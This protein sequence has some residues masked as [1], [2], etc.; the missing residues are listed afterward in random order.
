MYLYK[1]ALR[2]KQLRWIC[3]RCRRAKVRAQE[4]CTIWIANLATQSFDPFMAIASG[5]GAIMAPSTPLHCGHHQWHRCHHGPLHSI[6]LWPTL[7]DF[8][9]FLMYYVVCVFLKYQLMVK[10]SQKCFMCGINLLMF[11][12]T[13]AIF[14]L[15]RKPTFQQQQL[16]L[17]KTRAKCVSIATFQ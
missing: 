3:F 5:T 4:V 1:N 11:V 16:Q 7:S 14:V 12:I 8:P 6:A 2:S 15:P 13:T 9:T 17:L 10:P